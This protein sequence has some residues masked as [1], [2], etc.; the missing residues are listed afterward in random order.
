LCEKIGTEF[1]TEMLN[2]YNT[3]TRDELCRETMKKVITDSP[4]FTL[5]DVIGRE[6]YK[7]A[8]ENKFMHNLFPIWY[9]F[10]YIKN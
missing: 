10:G 3:K 1:V 2:P 6:M 8:K 9:M 5:Q 7:S 4:T